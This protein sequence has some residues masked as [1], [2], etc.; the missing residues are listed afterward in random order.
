MPQLHQG[1]RELLVAIYSHP[2]TPFPLPENTYTQ[3]VTE[4]EDWGIVTSTLYEPKSSEIWLYLTEHGDVVAKQLAAQARAKEAQ[5]HYDAI[6]K[7]TSSTLLCDALGRIMGGGKEAPSANELNDAIQFTK[8]AL[9][10]LKAW[11]IKR[12]EV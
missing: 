6:T 12:G 5:R 4:L 7:A 1:Q 8:H 3:T 9:S 2:S 11:A 10:Q